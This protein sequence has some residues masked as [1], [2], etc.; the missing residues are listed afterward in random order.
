VSQGSEAPLDGQAESE[1]RVKPFYGHS[2]I[3]LEQ[4]YDTEPDT[5]RLAKNCGARIYRVACDMSSPTAGLEL[6]VAV[7]RVRNLGMD[8]LVTATYS[9]PD[10]GEYHQV[11][12]TTE[13][14]TEWAERVGAVIK[15]N[16]GRVRAV[17]VWNEP[18][19][20]PFNDQP[21][22]ERWIPRYVDLLNKTY[23]EIKK[24]DRN[25]IVTTG[26][27]SPR[28]TDANGFSPIEW[29]K[30]LYARTPPRF[31][32][33]AHHPY[34]FPYPASTAKD[35]NSCWQT[36]TIAAVVRWNEALRSMPMKPIYA[37]EVNFPSYPPD[38]A[39]IERAVDERT[40]VDRFLDLAHLWRSWEWTGP[41]IWFGVRDGKDGDLA[42][43]HG[44]L[45]RAD[46]TPKP[47]VPYFREVARQG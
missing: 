14:R 25:I 17:E 39:P 20:R 13:Q 47:I 35:W 45:H 12:L 32:A 37:T 40:Q 6:E 1:L 18:N 23:R 34:S 15:R 16:V 21:N 11:P 42:K 44:G 33:L 8:V 7:D 30:G 19:H 29:T 28:G 10:L 43:T 2:L 4:S 38:H 22:L 36:L 41:L 27:T 5:L 24:A 46:G 3:G 31:D 26:G 9:P